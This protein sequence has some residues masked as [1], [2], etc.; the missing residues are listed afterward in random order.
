MMAAEE[1]QLTSSGLDGKSTAPAEQR[2]SRGDERALDE[3]KPVA[4]NY[5]FFHLIF[6][7]ASLYVAMLL[8]DWG[9]N[10]NV[11]VAIGTHFHA[12][13]LGKE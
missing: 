12:D 11:D 2:T 1:G 9:T 13:A 4:Y 7:L 8:T 5:S 10:D 6:S 3:F